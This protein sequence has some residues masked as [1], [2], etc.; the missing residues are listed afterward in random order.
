MNRRLAAC[1]SGPGLIATRSTVFVAEHVGGRQYVA[2]HEPSAQQPA[3][4]IPSQGRERGAETTHNL[5]G[6]SIWLPTTTSPLTRCGLAEHAGP[7]PW[8]LPTRTDTLDHILGY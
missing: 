1:H 7:Y 2:D 5:P 3:T 6:N 8:H 4:T